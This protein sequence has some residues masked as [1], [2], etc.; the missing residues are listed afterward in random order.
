M[1]H[2]EQLREWI[3]DETR[4]SRVDPDDAQDA[5]AI[6]VQGEAQPTVAATVQDLVGLGPE[7]EADAVV[8]QDG[9]EAVGLDED[10]AEQYRN[11]DVGTVL[12]TLIGQ[13][14]SEGGDVL[15]RSGVYTI[16]STVTIPANVAV[17][18][19][20][21]GPTVLEVGTDVD[22]FTMNGDDG[23]LRDLTFRDPNNLHQPSGNVAIR[24]DTSGGER[25]NLLVEDIVFNGMARCIDFTPNTSPLARSTFKNLN[26]NECRDTGVRFANC[27]DCIWESIFV[28]NQ[29]QHNNGNPGFIITTGYDGPVS[30]GKVMHCTCLGR[31]G[32]ISPSKSTIPA[33]DNMRGFVF[34][35]IDSLFAESVIADACSDYGYWLKSWPGVSDRGSA[36]GGHHLMT[37]CW[38]AS[39]VNDTVNGHFDGHGFVLEGQE[40]HKLT[41]C[42]AFNNATHG[43]Y[44]R[45]GPIGRA[46]KNEFQ[47]CQAYANDRDWHF[48]NRSTEGAGFCDEDGDSNAFQACVSIGAWKAFVTTGTV[49][50]TNLQG[51]K[52]LDSRSGT[53]V[54]L[55]VNTKVANLVKSGEGRIV[56]DPLRIRAQDDANEGAEVF[57]E[58]AGQYEDWFQDVYQDRMRWYIPGK[59]EALRIEED[60]YKATLFGD[61]NIESPDPRMSFTD[62]DSG[63]T[64]AIVWDERL[65]SFVVEK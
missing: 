17:Q 33:E 4:V 15:V 37:N 18:G 23:V 54:D 59:G 14:G 43:F 35:G 12:N 65:N 46:R 32:G 51:C 31:N 24:I 56:T 2:E 52:A 1:G 64:A 61:L 6:L 62:Q 55:E 39:T 11:T 22:L 10:G 3:S 29:F 44:I 53:E 40:F 34:E 36:D 13:F 16:D 30:G 21:Y 9:T 57:W 41:G 49:G 58:G 50:D 7:H 38:V 27:W 47:A 5:L 25:R 19:T 42:K 45:S 48:N 20:A 26:V 60:P 28:R 63:S 8:Y